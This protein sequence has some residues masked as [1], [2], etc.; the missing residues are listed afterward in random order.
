LLIVAVLFVV[1]SL[2]LPKKKA[3]KPAATSAIFN[4]I[5]RLAISL[6]IRTKSE[7]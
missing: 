1:T 5:P 7:Y 3:T 6:S 2:F 4:Y